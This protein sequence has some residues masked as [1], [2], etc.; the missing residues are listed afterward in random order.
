MIAVALTEPMAQ[1]LAMADDTPCIKLCVIEPRSGLCFGCG[2]SLAE[3]GRWG[4]LPREE[5]LRIMALLPQRMAEA[6]VS[7]EAMMDEGAPD[8]DP[9]AAA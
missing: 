8:D 3:I 2:R 5:R 6:G 4:G 9:D 1:Q 7:P